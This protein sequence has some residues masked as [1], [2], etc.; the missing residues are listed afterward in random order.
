MQP[1][2]LP[3][4]QRGVA[5]FITLM[6]LIIISILGVSAMRS[7]ITN[8]RIATGIQGR[9]ISFQ[10]AQSGINSALNDITYKEGVASKLLATMMTERTKNSGVKGSDLHTYCVVNGSSVVNA[11]TSSQF[12]GTRELAQS[13]YQVFLEKNQGVVV[14]YSSLANNTIIT[15]GAGV[16]PA[17]G[18][19]NDNVQELTLLAPKVNDVESPDW[20]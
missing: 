15:G 1:M 8:A 12:V 10:A 7:S 3:N 5:L 11:C 19:R 17:L 2:S 9:T 13:S 14:G 16:V 6:I 18:M 20:N 4:A